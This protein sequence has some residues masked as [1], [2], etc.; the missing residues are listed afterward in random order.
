MIER[1]ITIWSP[2]D[3]AVLGRKIFRAVFRL[4][5]SINLRTHGSRWNREVFVVGGI[6]Q[7]LMALDFVV[8]MAIFGYVLG[9]AMT[10]FGL[11]S[12]GEGGCISIFSF[13]REE[14]CWQLLLQ[15][16]CRGHGLRA[17]Q[18]SLI[19]WLGFTALRRN[20]AV[21]F[22]VADSETSRCMQQVNESWQAFDELAFKWIVK[23]CNTLNQQFWTGAQ[24]HKINHL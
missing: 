4:G 17:N 11:Q 9:D 3:P 5:S 7:N 2:H 14:T 16:C 10:R 15:S 18:V 8:Q 13:V 24:H 19:D 21:H 22:F 20:S 12:S 6:I 23:K 1:Y